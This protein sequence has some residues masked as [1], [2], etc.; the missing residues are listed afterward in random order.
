MKFETTLQ[1]ALERDKKTL[2]ARIDTDSAHGGILV[3]FEGYGDFFSENGAGWP[4]LIE[5]RD[6]VPC[7]VI[8][9]DINKEGPTHVISLENAAE[10][11]FKANKR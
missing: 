9:S 7:V 4:I 2:A 3:G 8:W 5:N 1:N 10:S 11:K 6:G